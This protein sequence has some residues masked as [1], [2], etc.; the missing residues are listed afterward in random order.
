LSFS[1]S[2]DDDK[3]KDILD[4]VVRNRNAFTS[5]ANNSP[6]SNIHIE[7]EFTNST[8]GSILENV[9]NKIRAKN[10]REE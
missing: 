4:K 2:N 7:H 8:V 6:Q 10:K 3:K 1:L 5:V 9:S